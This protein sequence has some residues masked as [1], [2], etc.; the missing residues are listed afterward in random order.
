MAKAEK[1]PAQKK[2]AEEK[3]VGD[4]ASAEKNIPNV[5][6][7][8]KK[9]K[10]DLSNN[11]LMGAITDSLASSNLKLVIAFY[12]KLPITLQCFAC[13][14]MPTLWYY[15]SERFLSL[16]CFACKIMPTLWYYVSERFL[17]V[18][19]V[20]FVAGVHLQIVYSELLLSC[21]NPGNLSVLNSEQKHSPAQE[22]VIRV[23]CRLTEIGF[24]P[25]P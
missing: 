25:S 13:K 14:I 7:A 4:K 3:K 11:Q 16:Q 2:P 15:V 19:F 20:I 6:N 12:V 8:G 9:K 22:A 1:K 10:R 24:E 21:S 5:G 18:T 23:H 17:F